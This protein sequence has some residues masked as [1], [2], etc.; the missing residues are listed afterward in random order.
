M[1]HLILI[2]IKFPQVTTSGSPRITSVTC[3]IVWELLK[4]NSNKLD[5]KTSH[6]I[7]NGAWGHVTL[8]GPISSLET[9]SIHWCFFGDQIMS[10]Y[11]LHA[12]VA[13]PPTATKTRHEE[14]WEISDK[15][16]NG[17]NVFVVTP[18]AHTHLHSFICHRCC[19]CFP[20]VNDCSPTSS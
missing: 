1:N 5:R 12:V 11:F 9:F 18:R 17:M 19:V 10:S 7:I 20:L 16:R 15:K 4:R 3:T 6:D 8:L 2:G 14:W 13:K